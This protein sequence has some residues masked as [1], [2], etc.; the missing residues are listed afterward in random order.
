MDLLGGQCVQVLEGGSDADR[1]LHAV[2][3]RERRRRCV[4]GGRSSA[5]E[6]LAQRAAGAELE[7][8]A[9]LRAVGGEGEEAADV[10]VRDPGQQRAVRTTQTR[11]GCV[12]GG[13]G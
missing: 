1:D 11:G 12:S 7:H 4:A 2:L 10:G 6:A 13:R 3:P 9:A 8:E 5:G